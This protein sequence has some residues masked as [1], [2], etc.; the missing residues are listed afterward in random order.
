MSRH[1]SI[2]F[3]SC[4]LF[5]MMRY[6]SGIRNSVCLIHG[7]Q[8]CT[9]MNRNTV[10]N[11]NGYNS[12]E[13]FTPRIYTTGMNEDDTIFGG[14]AKLEAALLE[15]VEDFHPE[16]IF[17]LNCCV[18]ELTGENIDDIAESVEESTGIKIIPV[19][20]AGFKGNHQAGYHDAARL[21][22]RHFCTGHPRKKQE[23]TVNLLGEFDTRHRWSSEMR[24]YMEAAGIRILATVPVVCSVEELRDSVN[25]DLNIVFCGNAAMALARE[26]EKEYG[27]PHVGGWGEQFGLNHS[28]KVYGEI[29]SYFGM[30]DSLFHEDMAVLAH[31]IEEVKSQFQGKTAA[32]VSGT[33]RALG[34]GIM[35]QELGIQVKYIFSESCD[36]CGV[37]K[38]DFLPLADEVICDD[39]VNNI[40]QRLAELA[41]DILFTT[42][43][44]LA[45]PHRFVTIRSQDYSGFEGM[46]AMIDVL[47]KAI[48]CK[49]SIY[50]QNY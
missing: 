23:N 14:N 12:C 49:H 24:R 13:I 47:L 39:G 10:Y 11:L 45:A 38:E 8:G 16:I 29:F 6:F 21:L 2:G 18:S 50:F 48:E 3:Q 37:S 42:L 15:I 25:A 35:L 34:Y 41:A 1:Y 20:S 7:P 9:F 5:G 17:V 32:I 36:S 30:D 33:R 44:E 40:Q 46:H 19:H 22:F 31:R 26:Y 27:I 28:A 4:S 43:P